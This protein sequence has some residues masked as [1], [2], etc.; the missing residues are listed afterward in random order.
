M[1][2][3]NKDIAHKFVLTRLEITPAPVYLVTFCHLMIRTAVLPAQGELQV[4]CFP[5]RGISDSP[6]CTQKIRQLFSSMEQD[7]RLELITTTM[8]V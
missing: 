6:C 5:G 4:S 2:V 1:N 8:L 3:S 7:Q